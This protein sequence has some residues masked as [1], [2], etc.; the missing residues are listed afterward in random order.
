MPKTTLDNRFRC[1]PE[2]WRQFLDVCNLLE[3]NHK[4]VMVALITYFVLEKRLPSSQP[5]GNTYYAPVSIP[6]I[7]QQTSDPYINELLNDDL[8]N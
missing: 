1:P 5:T 3:V 8:F 4:Q 6:E 2:L 7:R